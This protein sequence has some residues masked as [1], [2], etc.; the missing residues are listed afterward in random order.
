V[1]YIQILS[2]TLPLATA[3]I[4]GA[5]IAM[6][7]PKLASKYARLIDKE[8]EDYIEELQDSLKHY[9]NKASNMERGPKING[10]PEEW[11]NLLPDVL[12]NFGDF[13]PKWLKPFLNNK[14]VQSVLVDKI[15]K[16]PDKFAGYFSKL[17]KN[18]TAK[19]QDGQQEEYL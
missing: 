2:I 11:S 12:G 19:K 13:A 3:V 8:R 6:N 9:K 17:I 7:R 5:K 14:E 18:S 4:I 16:D 15:Q 1:E 10:S